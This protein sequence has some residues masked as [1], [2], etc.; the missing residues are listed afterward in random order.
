MHDNQQLE[1]G[2]MC[3]HGGCMNYDVSR[4]VK[5]RPFR[6]MMADII[7][8]LAGAWWGKNPV[9]KII[10]MPVVRGFQKAF[11]TS[12]GH[13]GSNGGLS[14][15]EVVD[16]GVNLSGMCVQVAHAITE[17][18]QSLTPQ[19]REELLSGI[20]KNMSGEEVSS[21]LSRWCE[22]VNQVY[23]HNPNLLAQSLEE[24][25]RR[26]IENTDMAEA[27]ELFEKMSGD[28]VGVSRIVNEVLWQ[29]PA[30]VVL[31][32]SLLPDLGNMIITILADTL[33]HMNTLSPDLVGDVM[34]SLLR[35][36]DGE[37][38]AEL[39]NEAAELVR[40][41]DTGSSLLGEPG[42]PQFPRELHRFFGD[43]MKHADTEKLFRAGVSMAAGKRSVHQS[44]DTLM[45]E[46]EGTFAM[47]ATCRAEMTNEGLRARSHR[48]Q[49]LERLGG[50][51]AARVGS[52]WTTALDQQAVAD[53][54]NDTLALLN[55]IHE[56][57]PESGSRLLTGVMS[58]VDLYELEETVK[59]MTGDGA[60]IL[61]PAGRAIMPRMVH[62]LCDMLEHSDD[63]FEEEAAGARL[64]LY[65]LLMKE[66]ARS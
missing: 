32:L 3:Q 23:D 5:T 52:A 64:R 60:A 54:I 45:R 63:E 25:I 24:P 33:K 4:I 47:A 19:E 6:K 9:K 18:V 39:L 57:D 28:I 12:P 27:R 37:R 22:I 43:I 14:S 30:K 50:Q 51:E 42:N 48:L 2:L 35:K 11:S 10:A 56:A 13:G 8:G 53:N 29:Y 36:M 34:L 40:K 31:L 61:K 44:M 26:W 62:M 16:L 21:L 20:T 65:N 59:W 41:L 49:S 66:E 15:E 58:Q 38:T 46:K 17:S 1:A 7:P 55:R